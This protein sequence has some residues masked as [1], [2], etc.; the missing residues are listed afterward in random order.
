MKQ[1]IPESKK[2]APFFAFYIVGSVQVGIGVLSFQRDIAKVA[3]YD[4]W[5]SIIITGIVISI[6]V[7]MMYK[8]FKVAKGGF[9]A[10]HSFIFGKAI[11][12][13]IGTIIIA[14]LI[15]LAIS[16]VRSYTEIVQVWMFERLSTFWFSLFFLLAV[17]YIVSGGIRTVTGMSFL[18]FFL[19]IMIF[20]VS[21][22]TLP[23]S[24][25]SDLLPIFNHSFIDILMAGKTMTLTIV[26]FE[27]ML[28]IIPFIKEPET[29]KKWVLYSVLFTTLF[30]LILA[31]LSFG[32][33]PENQLEKNIWPSL[34]I[35]KIIEFPF[36][37]RFEYIGIALW[38]AI[39]LPNTSIVIWCAGRLVKEIFSIKQRTITPF[40]CGVV[41]IGCLFLTSRKEI[42]AFTSFVSEISFY[43]CFVYLPLLF[44][45]T[46]I[47]KG[48][49]KRGQKQ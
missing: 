42:A 17:I 13:I 27:V 41:L 16:S 33:F 20:P 37:E 14:Y 2:L 48:V 1:S 8:M 6:V 46:M 49:K 5:I 25:F 9:L 36:I 3:G 31:I 12:K 19:P 30:Y 39:V 22:F 29:S 21:L 28:F 11:S 7:L 23:Y 24:D 4:A 34:T 35:W 45:L 44:L 15:M 38:F 47:R 18:S 40:L 10:I 43:F 32:Y 26:G